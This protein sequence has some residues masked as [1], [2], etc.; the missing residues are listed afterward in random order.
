LRALNRR[1]GGRLG[2]SVVEFSLFAAA[3]A[4]LVFGLVDF[5]RLL[6]ARHVMVNLSREGANLASR[7]TPVP[8]VLI[9]LANSA[10]PLDIDRNGLVI[11][12]TVSRSSS[13]TLSVT[14]QMK[15]GATNLV[16]SVSSKVG[17]VGASGSGVRTPNSG[18]PQAGQSAM[19]AEV[20]YRFQAATPVG[21]LMGW[22][23]P[24]MLY[25]VA[26]F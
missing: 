24:T 13:G 10:R 20:F 9:A 26:F 1:A 14:A 4:I 15:R 17:A 2:Q 8:D 11:L 18:V 21:N 25:D 3:M 12:T 6:S 19:V 22:A 7:G 23:L 5:G 16:T